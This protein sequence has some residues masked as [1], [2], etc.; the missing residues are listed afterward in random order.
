MRPFIFLTRLVITELFHKTINIDIDSCYR[1]TDYFINPF[2]SFH[3]KQL[4]NKSWGMYESLC[5]NLN[6]FPNDD[7][8]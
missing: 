8:N 5:K 1:P 6:T 2:L 3:Q 4:A 7:Q